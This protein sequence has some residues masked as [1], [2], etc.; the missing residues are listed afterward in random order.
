MP[1]EDDKFLQK[2]EDARHI[3]EKQIKYLV[4]K[5][6]IEHPYQEDLCPNCGAHIDNYRQ[7]MREP[8]CEYQKGGRDEFRS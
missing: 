1:K 8:C 5:D 6:S 3:R 7:E 4:W 2:L